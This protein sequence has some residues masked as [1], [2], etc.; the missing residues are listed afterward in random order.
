MVCN[1][2][3]KT[4]KVMIIAYRSEVVAYQAVQTVVALEEI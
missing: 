3:L 2:M 4:M 1:W